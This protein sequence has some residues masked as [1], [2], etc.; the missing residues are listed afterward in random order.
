[1][2]MGFLSFCYG[3]FLLLISY[4]SKTLRFLNKLNKNKKNKTIHS[5]LLGDA[6]D[7]S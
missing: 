2:L 5:C 6:Y 4:G 1:M 3:F 7:A